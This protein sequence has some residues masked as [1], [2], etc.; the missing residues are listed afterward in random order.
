V[1]TNWR[2]LRQSLFPDQ[3]P[4]STLDTINHRGIREDRTEKG[5]VDSAKSVKSLSSS[6]PSLANSVLSAESL[7]TPKDQP[8]LESR[9]QS[10]GISIAIDNLTG[11]ALL[12]FSESDAQAVQAVATVHK[13]F[14]ITLTAAQCRE[15]LA[16]LDYFE[17]LIARKKEKED[18]NAL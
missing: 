12:I 13:P 5:V 11:A 6:S 16:D 10:L 2:E 9:L 4:F 15:L 7:D 1:T 3:Q 17:R 8:A 18:S 14:D